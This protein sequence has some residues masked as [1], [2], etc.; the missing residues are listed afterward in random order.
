MKVNLTGSTKYQL[1][2]YFMK[3]MDSG[4]KKKKA[5]LLAYDR[6]DLIAEV[7]ALRR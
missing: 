5:K 1:T 2:D 7:K 4:R 6:L 3:P